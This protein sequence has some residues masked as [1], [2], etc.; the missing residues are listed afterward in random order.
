MY[1]H[2]NS[3]IAILSLAIDLWDVLNSRPNAS[4]KIVIWIIK[5]EI[6]IQTDIKKWIWI[7]TQAK[8]YQNLK[9]QPSR[10]HNNYKRKSPHIEIF[11]YQILILDQGLNQGPSD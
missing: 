1:L 7:K 2:V 3:F 9:I 10:V 4:L 5:D 6:E 8:D 11:F